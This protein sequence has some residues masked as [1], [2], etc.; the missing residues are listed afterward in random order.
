MYKHFCE[1]SRTFEVFD[2]ADFRHTLLGIAPSLTTPTLT[3]TNPDTQIYYKV[4]QSRVEVYD[5]VSRSLAGNPDFAELPHGCRI[6]PVWNLLWTWGRPN[7]DYSKLFV[8]QKV[9]HFP[10]SKFLSRKDCLKRCIDRYVKRP[11]G[12]RRSQM[13]ESFRVIPET[14]VLP[15]DYCEFIE[16]YTNYRDLSLPETM[17]ILK[18]VCLSRGRGISV[19]SDLSE[20]NYTE[21]TI[22]QKYIEHPLLLD[23]YKFD[24]RV[25]VLVMSFN[26][27]EAY[28]YKEGF[29][30][31]ATV[32]Y[33][34]SAEDCK[35]RLMHLTN[36]SVQRNH[37][38]NLP[39]DK[40]RMLGGT[41]LSFKD[42]KTRLEERD[43]GWGILWEK[44]KDVIVRTLIMC[45]HMI[46]FQANSFELYGFDV[47][48]D[49]S[50]R[51][52]LL[53]ANSSPSMNL[54][55][56][57]DERIKIALIRDTIGVV[58]PVPF[59]RRAVMEVLSRKL[60]SPTKEGA[61]ANKPSRR[62]WQSRSVGT[63]SL[64]P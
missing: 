38:D 8:W 24:L 58:N 9:N 22:I 60:D 49:E 32:K 25:Y 26:P 13:V 29:A 11:P 30:R 55:T 21:P 41:K 4:V 39:N 10:D 48:F 61:C 42:L 19:I 50:L 64:A 47:I 52:W 57:L 16:A 45:E 28:I 18:P 51:A 37:V 43:I 1:V 56:L 36:T 17:W 54:D 27:L 5:V 23:G 53:E 40:H 12:S 35:N 33:S 46:G 20:V 34:S 59:N 2:F 63:Q 6:G 7:I 14:F 62:R 15:R 31:L 3:K 44:I